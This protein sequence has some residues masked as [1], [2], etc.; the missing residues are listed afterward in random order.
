MNISQVSDKETASTNA[1]CAAQRAGHLAALG[2][3]SVLELCVGPSLSMLSKA[4]RSHRIT[5]VGNDI[6][7]RWQVFHP[8]GNWI[9]GDALSVESH[10]FEAVVFAPPLSKGCT[11]TREDALRIDEVRPKYSDFLNRSSCDQVNVLVLPARSLATPRDRE[12]F[13]KL[14]SQINMIKK[15]VDVIPLTAGRRKIT[16]YID[17][18]LYPRN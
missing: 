4:Y 2:V 6:E 17:V 11:G 5:V 3:R 7:K 8:E 1:E 13:Y 9:I 14:M 16:K 12:Q 10:Q 15:C 18:Y